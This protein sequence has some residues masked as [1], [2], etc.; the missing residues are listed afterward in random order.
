M[1]VLPDFHKVKFLVHG[2]GGGYD[3][4]DASYGYVESC[5]VD[6]EAGSFL[7]QASKNNIKIH[8][9]DSRRENLILDSGC[10][11]HIVNNDPYFSE[12]V[13]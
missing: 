12:N 1:R 8:A 5:G 9:S 3:S 7:T 2:R 6:Y 10:S 11:E 4:G 13:N